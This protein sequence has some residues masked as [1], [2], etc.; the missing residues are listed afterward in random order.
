MI[1][2]NLNALRPGQTAF[3]STIVHEFQ[4]MVHFARCPSQEGW[5]D[6]GASE[7]ATRVAGYERRRT[8]PRSRPS[9]TSSSTPGAGQRPELT[10][11]YQASYLFL[12]YV[13]ER[14]GGW[15]ALPQ[16]LRDVRAR[17]SALCRAS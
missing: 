4:H 1:Y 7:L 12:R 6:E 13:A 14:A 9:P 16:L 11:H 15:D 3:D 2:V 8:R 5:V 17:R 10:R